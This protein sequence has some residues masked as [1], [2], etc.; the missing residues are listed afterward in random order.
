[1]S[2]IQKIA[3]VAFCMSS[4][5]YAENRCERT[6][7]KAVASFCQASLK[8][9]VSAMKKLLP[10]KIS[11]AYTKFSGPDCKPV[12]RTV[13]YKSGDAEFKN[14]LKAFISSIKSDLEQ[15]ADNPYFVKMSTGR[16]GTLMMGDCAHETSI[17]F[18]PKTS[19]IDS[20]HL[21]ELQ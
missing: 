13:S 20:I 8:E 15:K 2:A 1:M 19:A 16:Y 18:N 17:N 7:L 6:L 21:D 10:T 9:D 3:L 14:V 4:L 5:A 12:V 11:V